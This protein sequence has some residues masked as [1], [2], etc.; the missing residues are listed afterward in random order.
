M[1]AIS[2]SAPAAARFRPGDSP[3]RLLL[4]LFLPVSLCACAGVDVTPLT[5]V[6]AQHMHA[7]GQAPAG[8]VVYAPMVVV[9]VTQQEVCVAKDDKGHCQAQETRCVAGKP[10]SLPD[11]TRPYLVSLRSGLGKAGSQIEITDGWMLGGLRDAADG[12]ASLGLVQ[13]LLSLRM[14]E[15]AAGAAGG[16]HACAAAGLYRA[17]LQ[18]A[19]VTLQPLLLY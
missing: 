15:G 10:F 5:A 1:R 7:G 4:S 12:T 16:G 2:A 19:Q 9:E 18:G 3:R 6:Q 13:K 14:A 17:S 8:Y 11:E